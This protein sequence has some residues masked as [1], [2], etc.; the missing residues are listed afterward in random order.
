MTTTFVYISPI[1]MIDFRIEYL[2]PGTQGPQIVNYLLSSS[3][4]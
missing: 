2:Q 1:D 4:L 3:I